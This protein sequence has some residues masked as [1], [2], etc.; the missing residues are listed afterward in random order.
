MS[1][2]ERLGV[3][4]GLRHR[5]LLAVVQVRALLTMVTMVIMSTHVVV[6]GGRPI[7]RASGG[8]QVVSSPDNVQNLRVEHVELGVVHVFY[9]LVADDPQA[10]FDVILQ[11]SQD[12]GETFD[13]RATSVSGDAGQEIG[14]GGGKRIVWEAG[15][16]VERMEVAKFVYSVV[17]RL[18][19]GLFPAAS[20]GP[21]EWMTSL[22]DTMAFLSQTATGLR[23]EFVGASRTGALVSISRRSRTNL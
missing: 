4:R 8:L 17:A 7:P 6:G 12:A 13:L 20:A 22:P 5:K 19:S 1:R 15:R 14:V 10:T 18:D 21:Q 23:L 3:G 2:D 16:D 9:D 11:V